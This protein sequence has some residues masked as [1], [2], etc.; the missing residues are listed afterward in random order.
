MGASHWSLLQTLM[1][2]SFL[3]KYLARWVHPDTI[4]LGSIISAAGL[5]ATW[6][7]FRTLLTHGDVS[8]DKSKGM[9]WQEAHVNKVYPYFSRERLLADREQKKT[10]RRIM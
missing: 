6:F 4:I 7:G 1:H 2:L 5:G 10:S 9:Q 8:I 3:P